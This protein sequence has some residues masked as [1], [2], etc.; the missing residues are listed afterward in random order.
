MLSCPRNVACVSRLREGL[1]RIIAQHALIE[2][3][4]SNVNLV[5]LSNDAW[6]ID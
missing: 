4:P 6:F 2:Q 3:V 1:Q 5:R